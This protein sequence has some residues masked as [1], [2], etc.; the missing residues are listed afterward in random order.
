MMLK[1]RC[2]ILVLLMVMIYSCD[3]AVSKYEPLDLMSHGMPIKIL[4]PSNTLIKSDDLGILKDLTIVD[5]LNGGY[6]IQIYS[7]KTDILD[8]AKLLDQIKLEIEATE[9]FSKMIEETENGFIYEKKV[10]EDYIN[11]DF[12][13]VRL[14][15]DVK[16]TIQAGFG[17]QYQIEDIESMFNAV[18]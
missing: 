14:Q 4:A 18:K 11:Y 12:R 10:T 3:N 2:L 1:F 6:N 9:F 13:V 5:T 7:S 8:R 16:Y 17:E 15:S